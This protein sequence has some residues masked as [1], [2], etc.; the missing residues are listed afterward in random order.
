MSMS[1]PRAKPPTDSPGA[2]DPF[3]AAVPLSL[4]LIGTQTGLDD[5]LR[6]SEERLRL[7]LWAA[8]MVTW[9]WHIPSGEIHASGSMGAMLGL[10]G[11]YGFVSPSHLA[12]VHP[13]DRRCI[14][15]ADR[16]A[17]EDGEDYA[18]EFRA[19]APDGSIRWLAEHGQ[20]FERDRQGRPIRIL[21]VVRDITEQRSLQELLT[22]QATHDP[23]TNLPNR[24]VFNAA[25]IT[26]LARENDGAEVAVLFLDLDG[27][28]KVNDRHGHD[29]GDQLLAMVAGRL[30]DALPPGTVITRM[31]GD[32]FTVLL[33][34]TSPDGAVAIARRL[35]AAV[36]L[37]FTVD[38]GVA[39]VGMCIGIA[40]CA[41]GALPAP[42][43]LRSADNAMYS[44]KARGAGSH[45]I[46]EWPEYPGGISPSPPGGR[47][48][49][50]VRRRS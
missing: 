9:E 50:A 11:S 45:A 13:D 8:R 15:E 46:F 32:E 7:A 37:P 3:V 22:F 36:D 38:I 26:S 43:L 12:N 35:I 31:G 41:P 33:E 28:K 16:A 27:F 10:G 5:R 40:C 44:A 6:D 21:G 39:R 23:L 20:V 18:I 4:P 25:L 14:L 17:I 19:I 30:R 24:A 29:I 42:D 34:R 2:T 1:E 49:P 48:R 47:A